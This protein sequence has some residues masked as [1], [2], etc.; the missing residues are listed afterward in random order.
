MNRAMANSSPG[1]DA[2]P[3]EHKAEGSDGRSSNKRVSSD[4]V[5]AGTSEQPS[6]M[7]N[8]QSAI[9]STALVIV[10]KQSDVPQSLQYMCLQ[11]KTVRSQGRD[12]KRE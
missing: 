12:L 8:S 2:D 6:L 4:T 1:L 7:T 10:E 3:G 9:A 11:G 5:F